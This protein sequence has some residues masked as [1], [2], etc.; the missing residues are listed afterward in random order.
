M[1]MQV[2]FL[3]SEKWLSLVFEGRNKEYGAYVQREESSDRHLKAIAVITIIALGLIFLPKII[4]SSLPTKEEHFGPGVVTLTNVNTKNLPE[5]NQLKQIVVPPP[6]ALKPTVRFTS[7]V[8]TADVNVRNE[9]L[10]KAQQDL[11]NIKADISIATIDGTEGGTVDIADV[12]K[13]QVIVED[14]TSKSAIPTYVEVMPEFPGGQAA[15]MKWLSDNINYPII[16][17]ERNIQGR[18]TLRF[19]VKP[20]GSVDDVVVMKG[21]DPSCD[22]EAVRVI[23]KMP[24]WLPGRQNGNAVSVYYSLPVV[25]KLQNN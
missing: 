1:I 19:V 25:F 20:D 15:L 11:T 4:K 5:D 17:Q 22:K 12:A 9:D 16:A 13:H 6:P 18:V 14:N 7:P 8:V 3:N 2:D 24:N 10:M 23:K 21:L